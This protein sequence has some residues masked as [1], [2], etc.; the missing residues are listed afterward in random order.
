MGWVDISP[1]HGVPDA[2]ACDPADNRVPFA[3]RPR[4]RPGPMQE[5]VDTT[6]HGISRV[7]SILNLIAFVVYVVDQLRSL[8]IFPTVGDT[9]Y[10]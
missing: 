8:I 10:G 3:R 7:L 1:S 2:S 9:W 5:S 6:A 4:T